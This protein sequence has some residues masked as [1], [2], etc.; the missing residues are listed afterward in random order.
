MPILSAGANREDEKE[1]HWWQFQNRS[2]LWGAVPGATLVFGLDLLKDKNW[3]LGSLFTVGSIVA[4]LLLDRQMRATSAP[5]STSKSWIAQRP[6]ITIALL[7]IVTLVGVI[8][9]IYDR[10]FSNDPRQ[11]PPSE[12]NAFIEDLKNSVDPGTRFHVFC[13]SDESCKI[14]D[15]YLDHVADAGWTDVNGHERKFNNGI[16]VLTRSDSDHGQA[17]DLRR[18]FKKTSVKVGWYND[19]SYQFLK[20]SGAFGLVIG[21][22][23]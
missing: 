17:A 7:A 11:L 14:A 19:P 18:A 6:T 2:M 8:Y 1:R 10:H 13:V 12:V 15:E 21:P 9:D 4:L 5:I 16:Y 22:L 3:M 20:E 23:K